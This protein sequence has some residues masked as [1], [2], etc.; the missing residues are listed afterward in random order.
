MREV[1][2]KLCP[3]RS[4][5]VL[6]HWFIHDEQGPIETPAG[7]VLT[8]LGPLRLGGV[9]GR[10][11]CQPER[12]RVGAENI[13]GQH[14]LFPH[15]DDLRAVT[16]ALCRRTPEARKMLLHLQ[17]LLEPNNPDVEIKRAALAP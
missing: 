10:I 6:I 1:V 5:R 7:G 9:K 4:G 17:E 16:C 8:A 14:H 15:S 12:A 11:A 2:V 13:S 3:D